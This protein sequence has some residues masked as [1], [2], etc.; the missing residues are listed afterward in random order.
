MSSSARPTGLIANSG[1]ELL[2][3]GTPN[4]HKATIILEELKEAYGKQYTVQA[5]NIMENIQKEPW[6]VKFSPNGRI[7]AI[8]DHD[9]NQFPVFEGSA[10]LAYLTRHYDPEHKFSFT[11]P[12]DVSRAEQWVAWQHGGLG[13][14]QGQ[15]NHFYRF[16]K[17]RIP[18]P[19]QRYLGES[20]RLY[21]IL[22]AQLK[23]RDYLVGP[24]RG[25]YSVADI[26]S[27]GWVNHAYLAGVD[28]TQFPNV[29]IWWERIV[30]RPAVQK[31]ITV[32]SD[33]KMHNAGYLKRL[34]EE[35]EFR[36]SEE[37]LKDLAKKAKE[38]YNYK[39][40]SP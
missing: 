20:E 14:M 21:G 34:Q 5:I 16:S 24:G 26:A 7:P 23:D 38:Q 37:K 30:A 40:S 15:S 35:P 13:P 28:L 25:K 2:T 9:R 17:E 3:A 22:N 19:T 10:I 18:Y 27:F 29:Q 11:D 1:I 8:V 32:P 39:Y 4:G 6:F 31:G 12:D 36:E 33:S